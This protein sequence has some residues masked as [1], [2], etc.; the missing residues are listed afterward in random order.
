MIRSL[1]VPASAI[2]L[3]VLGLGAAAQAPS[4]LYRVAFIATT[5]PVS[6]LK[7]TNPASQGFAR[8]MR[9]LGYIEGRN[10]IIE[11]R[12]AE[13]RF[14]RTP[15]IVRELV[16]RKVEVIVT[17]ANPMTKAAKEVTQTVPIVM[18]ASYEP[19][20]Q[21][22]VQSL[23]RPG[24]NVTGLTLDW[25]AQAL[26]KR[27]ELLSALLPGAKRA[28]I[29]GLK[30]EGLDE[31]AAQAAGKAL[32]IALI[33]V[34][35]DPANRYAEAF[36]AIARARP[37]ALLVSASGVNYAYRRELAEFAARSALPT[38]Y[39]T[40]D[41]VEVGGLVSYGVD[42]GELFRYAASYVDRI[43]RGAR[44]AELPVERPSKLQLAINLKSA[45]AL[46]LTIPQSLLLRADAIV[47]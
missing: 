20:A 26:G 10:L 4:K 19:V 47:E 30:F 8:G 6:E 2:V 32:G 33:F 14:E 13:G 1:V 27:L 28:V 9:E 35:P 34:E 41:Y 5:S 12:T 45:K 23:A 29:L 7:T 11:W 3:A 17:V 31:R 25:D 42:V 38:M 39:P 16:S 46:G 43:L 44:P 21:G 36:A 40:R 15:D 18:A 24:G 22:L 37:D